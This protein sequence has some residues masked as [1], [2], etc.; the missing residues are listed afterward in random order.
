MSTVKPS[1]R[2]AHLSIA[3]LSKLTALMLVAAAAGCAVDT[4][5]DPSSTSSAIIV[6]EPSPIDSNIES[7]KALDTSTVYALDS[8]GNLWKET[9]SP[10]S[11]TK[12]DG[13][14]KAF[15]PLAGDYWVYVLGTDGNLWL[16]PNGIRVE[17]TWPPASPSS[18]RS[19]SG[20]STG[21]TR[22]TTS[23]TRPAPRRR[24]GLTGT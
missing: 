24:R 10:A 17:A 13:N 9:L 23:G 20:S 8:S 15:Q 3:P 12:I 18:R 4:A 1:A 2:R 21:R 16:E 7:F 11:H 22:T 19:R 5:E 6:R 14:V